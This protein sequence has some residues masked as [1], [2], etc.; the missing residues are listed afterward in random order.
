MQTHP[1]MIM[2]ALMGKKYPL[3]KYINV[4]LITVDVTFHGRRRRQARRRRRRRMG[5]P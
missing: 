5:Q 1:V 3:R 4:S 2:G